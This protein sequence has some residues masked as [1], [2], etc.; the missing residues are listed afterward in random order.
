M[1]EGRRGI[2]ALLMVLLGLLWWANRSGTEQKQLLFVAV[3]LPAGAQ[4]QYRDEQGLW[5]DGPAPGWQTM[6]E[7]VYAWGTPLGQ[8]EQPRPLFD[9]V[10]LGER[11]NETVQ[12][13][14]C[15]VSAA[16]GQTPLTCWQ[17]MRGKTS[18]PW[19]ASRERPGQA[20]FYS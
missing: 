4:L 9:R 14:T 11:T 2:G 8:Q 18:A 12:V 13:K 10:R 7:G 19:P 3:Q 6:A 15:R 5:Q 20:A 1:A 17:G 16:H